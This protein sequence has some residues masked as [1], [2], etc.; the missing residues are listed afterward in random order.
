MSLLDYTVELLEKQREEQ[1]RLSGLR[2]SRSGIQKKAKSDF[3][4]SL[5]NIDRDSEIKK[6]SYC[7]TEAAVA[8]LGGGLECIEILAALLCR[9]R[10]KSNDETTVKEKKRRE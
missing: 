10:I 3:I 4:S 8:A 6:S 1:A 7:S 9:A 2:S 5:S